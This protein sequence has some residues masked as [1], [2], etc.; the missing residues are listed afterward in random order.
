MAVLRVWPI[1]LGSRCPVSFRGALFR[2]FAKSRPFVVIRETLA[3]ARSRCAARRGGKTDDARALASHNAAERFLSLYVLVLCY[4]RDT[5]FGSTRVFAIFVCRLNDL[6]RNEKVKRLIF[7]PLCGM[8]S[9]FSR[10]VA[11]SFNL[12]VNEKL[13]LQGFRYNPELA[14]FPEAVVSCKSR[15]VVAGVC[16]E[17]LFTLLIRVSGFAALNKLL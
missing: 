1:T 10:H 11:W 17:D 2:E 8:S 14:F 16:E 6:W 9:A 12:E 5:L 3:E 15:S 13:H 7:T 4:Y